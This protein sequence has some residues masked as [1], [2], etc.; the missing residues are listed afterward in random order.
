MGMGFS[1]VRQMIPAAVICISGEILSLHP[2]A[3]GTQLKAD[4][5]RHRTDI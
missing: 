5:K 3:E 2:Q 1:V 4:W